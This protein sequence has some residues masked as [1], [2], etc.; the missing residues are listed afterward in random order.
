[1]NQCGAD[2]DPSLH[3]SMFLWYITVSDLTDT[4][5]YFWFGLPIYDNRH[6]FSPEFAQQDGGKEDSTSSFIYNPAADTFLDIPVVEGTPNLLNR[7]ML[8]T[9]QYA[10]KLAQERGFMKNTK[11]EN[12]GITSMYIGWELPGTFDV[13]MDVQNMR[14]LAG[15]K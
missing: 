6:A 4:S 3:S 12:L 1:M 15:K 8:P 2:Y 10:F 9:I 7:D 5:E 14:L 13:G 11:Y